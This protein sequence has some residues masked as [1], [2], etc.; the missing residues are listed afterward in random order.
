MLIPFFITKFIYAKIIFVDSLG[1]NSEPTPPENAELR[2]SK[3]SGCR[4]TC[5]NNYIFPNG[6]QH[7]FI[8]CE[9]NI[10]EVQ[11]TEW[12]YIPPC[13]RKL[14]ILEYKNIETHQYIL[15]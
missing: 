9:E 8:T 5:R 13:E 14:S 2:C 3:F 4:A 7:I 11:G 10:W 6:D 12:N 15:N 1:C